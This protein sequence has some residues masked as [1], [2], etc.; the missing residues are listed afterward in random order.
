MDP[1]WLLNHY[2]VSD[3]SN[4]KQLNWSMKLEFIFDMFIVWSSMPNL[5]A[6]CEDNGF[7]F[8][9]VLFLIYQI[10]SNEHNQNS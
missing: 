5:L 3:V 2:K 4:A 9:C 1:G 6:K 7:L 10:E 8:L